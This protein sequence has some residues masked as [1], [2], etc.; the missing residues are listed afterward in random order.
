[1]IFEALEGQQG[2][3]GQVIAQFFS[4]CR[5]LFSVV[6]LAAADCKIIDY[7]SLGGMETNLTVGVLLLFFWAIS[8]LIFWKNYQLMAW[9]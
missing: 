6:L 4:A 9:V 7:H 1:M 3:A 2:V 5:Y 8:L